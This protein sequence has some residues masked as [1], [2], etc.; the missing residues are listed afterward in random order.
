MLDLRDDPRAPFEAALAKLLMPV[1]TSWSLL[2]IN[3][4]SCWTDA[5]ILVHG[6]S[7]E[8]IYFLT[9]ANNGSTIMQQ[10]A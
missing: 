2:H 3:G 8:Y 6:L 5:P 4:H 1:L 9:C 7:P 10:V